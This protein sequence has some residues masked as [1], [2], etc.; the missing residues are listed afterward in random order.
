MFERFTHE[1][2]AVVVE[3]QAECRRRHD[4]A[5]GP[6]HLLLGLWFDADN[7]AVRVLEQLGLHRDELRDQLPRSLPDRDALR[8]LGIDIDEV[9][10]RIEA[11]FGPGALE[12]TA[13]GCR[14]A[15]PFTPTGKQALELALRAALELGHRSIGPA[16]VLLGIVRVG[17]G[18]VARVLDRHGLAPDDVRGAVLD[19]L[20]HAA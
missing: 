18:D 2:R 19:E 4:R 8:A 9:R 17:D 5:I 13:A 1:A 7:P 15:V 14:G 20:A 6:E 12:S 3:A 11:A 10:R 16:H